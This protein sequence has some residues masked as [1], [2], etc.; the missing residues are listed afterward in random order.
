MTDIPKPV[1]E[2][3]DEEGKLSQF[4]QEL[5]QETEAPEA[6]P[7]IISFVKY[8]NKLCEI[9]ALGK[10][11]GNKALSILKEIG[12]KVFSR[13]DFQ[14]H[15]IRTDGIANSGEYGKLYSGLG[16]DIEV[17][18]LFLQST[19]RIFYFDIEPEGML[20]IVAIRE[21]H[22]ETDKIRR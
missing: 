9:S 22:F 15:N 12:M 17:R 11:K 13:A 3:S 21:N 10:N 20:Y 16:P 18:E 4:A 5:P 6:I 2:P 8:N 7:Y 14:R 19:G 1:T